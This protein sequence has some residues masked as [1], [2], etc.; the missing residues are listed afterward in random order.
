MSR[1]RSELRP[2]MSPRKSARD[3]LRDHVEKL[4]AWGDEAARVNPEVH[5]DYGPHTILKL[6]ALNHALDVFSPIA[7][8]AVKRG[9]YDQ[10]VYLDLFSGC[11]VTRIPETGDF[12]AGSPVLAARAKEPFDELLL[13]EKNKRYQGALEQ[14]LSAAGDPKRQTF[15]GDVNA[16][17][18]KLAKRISERPSIVFACV[19]PEGMEIFWR[20]MEAISRPS[21]ATDFFVTL[22]CGADRALAEASEGGNSRPAVERMMGLP[23]EEVLADGAGQVSAQY[24]ARVREV[25]GKQ[26]G[27][28]TLIRDR[29]GTPRYRLLLYARETPGGSPWEKA[30]TDLHR[31]LSELS[32]EDALGALNIIKR[33][34]IDGGE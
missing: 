26:L 25:L 4:C 10:S 7:R 18:K 34:A 17:A 27:R 15:L 5:H 1:G 33:R 31:R 23:L 21:V 2:S 19:D 20:T 14:R 8:G 29:T 6:A 24:I 28:A 11:G 16:I 22:T 9:R 32:A 3:W 30:Y 12:V 13:V